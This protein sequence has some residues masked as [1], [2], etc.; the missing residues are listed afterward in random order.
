[1]VRSTRS[2]WKVP[3]INKL[4]LGNN[5]FKSKEFLTTVRNVTLTRQF[6]KKKILLLSGKVFKKVKVKVS[7]IGYKLGAFT[8]T[9]IFGRMIA[10]SMLIK[11]RQKKQ[12]KKKK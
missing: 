9:K 10:K 7:M 1:M 11:A 3:Y 2:I 8:T 4:F 5:F 6:R 12:D